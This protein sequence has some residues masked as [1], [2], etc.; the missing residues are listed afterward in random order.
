[1]TRRRRGLT[2]RDVRTP[3]GRGDAQ[4]LGDLGTGELVAHAWA[5]VPAKPDAGISVTSAT[6]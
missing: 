6:R 4:A 1:M 3:G 2:T 5:R